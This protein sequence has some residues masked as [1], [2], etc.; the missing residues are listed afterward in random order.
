MWLPLAVVA[1]A[2]FSFNGIIDKIVV[3]K[4]VKNPLMVSFWV[5]MTG[6]ITGV[7]LLLGLLPGPLGHTLRLHLPTLPIFALIAF[8]EIVLQLGL[9]MQYTALRHGEATRVISVIGASMP[10]FAF[11]F[12][13]FLLHERLGAWGYASFAVLMAGA[14]FML[15]RRGRWQA[16]P[17]MLAVGGA[18]CMAFQTVVARYVYQHNPFISSLL[19]FGVGDMIYNTSLFLLLPQVRRGAQRALRQAKRMKPN[20][21]THSTGVWILANAVLGGTGIVCINLALKYGPAT[22]VN[23]LKGLQYTGVFVIALLVSRHY[24][25]LLK[26]ELS[27]QTMRQ[28]L[29]AIVVIGVGLSLLT[30]AGR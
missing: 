22:L 29:L 23:A 24:P 27:G 6:W 11:G 5:S 10:V 14:L 15:V 2:I 18:G 16:M 13:Y 9:L 19:L 30:L 17:F 1:Y 28:K 4:K 26:E 25:K 3:S 7:I 12:A 20:R 21:R 8:G